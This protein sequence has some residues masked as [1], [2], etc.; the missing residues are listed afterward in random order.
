MRA[1]NIKPGFFKN[2]ELAEVDPL[3]RLLFAGLWCLADREGRLEDRPRKIKAEVLPYD[4]CDVE[5]LLEE[6]HRRGFILRYEAAGSF[7][8][9]I[10][11]F[12][13]HQNPHHREAASRFPGPPAELAPGGGTAARTVPGPGNSGEGRADSLIPDLRIPDSGSRDPEPS[14]NSAAAAAG[15]SEPELADLLAFFLRLTGRTRVKPTELEAMRRVLAETG[16]LPWVKALIATAYRRYQPEYAADKISSFKYFLP[17]I[18]E[19]SAGRRAPAPGSGPA[20]PGGFDPA[21]N[22]R[23][24]A[25]LITLLPTV[26]GKEEWGDGG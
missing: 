11:A 26:L 5:G 8:I 4:D 23:I 10:P 20:S 7:L 14:A 2:E 21:E 24:T 1:R 16:D 6:L 12:G 18:A 17:I 25:E 19:A 3:G 15:E 9:A 13:I 22:E